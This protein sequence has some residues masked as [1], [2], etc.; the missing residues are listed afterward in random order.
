[1][2]PVENVGIAAQE[3]GG[4]PSLIWRVRPVERV[5]A[6]QGFPVSAPGPLLMPRRRNVKIGWKT[7]RHESQ[8]QFH[9]SS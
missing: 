3:S 6:C 4:K 1:M 2:G 8:P 7:R 9:L 5:L